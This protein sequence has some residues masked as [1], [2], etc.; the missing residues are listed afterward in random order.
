MV[1]MITSILGIVET[2]L[3]IQLNTLNGVYQGVLIVR[4]N[5]GIIVMVVLST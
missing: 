5:A 4:K 2:R 3:G 1:D